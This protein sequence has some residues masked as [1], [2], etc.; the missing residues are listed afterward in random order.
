MEV[1]KYLKMDIIKLENKYIIVKILNV[2][3]EILWK[4]IP[5]KP[6]IQMCVSKC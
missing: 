3:D 6:V 4:I 5:I 2:H 1:K